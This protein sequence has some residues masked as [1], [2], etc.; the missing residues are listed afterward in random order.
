MVSLNSCHV[1]GLVGMPFGFA[2]VTER[3]TT[4]RPLAAEKKIKITI[5]GIQC[6]QWKDGV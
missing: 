2:M 3:K 6:V 5:M 1:T 4:T